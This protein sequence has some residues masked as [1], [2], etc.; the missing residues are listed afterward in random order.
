[1]AV[2]NYSRAE[3]ETQ[4][5]MA[6]AL[7]IQ[8]GNGDELTMYRIARALGLQPSTHVAQIL[9]DMVVSGK[10]KARWVENRPGKWDTVLYSLPEGTYVDPKATAR[11]IPVKVR[12]V[13]SEQ[14]ELF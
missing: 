3:R 5:K 1:M 10:L 7:S 13:L 14:L 4:I 11:Q 2:K 6:I 9:A 12:G 8:R